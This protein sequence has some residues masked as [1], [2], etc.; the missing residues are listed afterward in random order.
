VSLYQTHR[1]LRSR[2]AALAGKDR[3][4]A[5]LAHDLRNPLNTIVTGMSVLR[6][7]QLETRAKA[8][9]DRVARAADRMT[10]MIRDLLDYSR[11]G[12]GAMPVVPASMDL[13]ELCQELV[14]EFE[15]ADPSREIALTVQGDARGEWDRAR[16]YQ[17][18]SNLVGNATHYGRGRA[19]VNV[20]GRDA[21]VQVVVYND[22]APIPPELLPTIFEPF[23]RGQNDGT[24]LGLGLYIVR[25]I[26]RAHG[27]DVSVESSDGAGTRFFLQLPRERPVAPRA[28][29]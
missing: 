20:S 23:E 6:H 17:A 8:T 13:G 10:G 21:D 5:V 18:L 29:A 27:G 11:A 22:G 19:L 7:G 16:L 2:D 24:G 28:P 3:Q 14:D 9:L 4:I 25:T 1:T 12:T 26:A 15:T